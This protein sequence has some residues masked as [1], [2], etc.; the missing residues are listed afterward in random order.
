VYGFKWGERYP[1]LASFQV[2]TGL[3]PH[4]IRVDKNTCFETFDVPDAPPASVPLQFMTLHADCN[5]VDAGIALPNVNDGYL[6]SA[7]DLG[8]YEVGAD[9]PQYG[10]REAT[11]LALTG[12][13][14][15]RAIQLSW[16]VNVSVP[17]AATWQISYDGPAGDEPSPITGIPNPTRAYSLTGLTNCAPYTVTLNAMLEGAPV[18]TDTVS[19][20]PTDIFVF[21]PLVE[22]P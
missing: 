18:L 3:E 6:G 20:M 4:A 11:A 10:P 14:S 17:A 15:D 9:L 22:R 19:V 7:P 13:P 2:A 16:E 5:A 21:L 8:A 12:T 1:D